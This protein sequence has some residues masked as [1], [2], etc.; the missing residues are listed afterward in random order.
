MMLPS[1]NDAA[2]TIAENFGDYI[3]DEKELDE[4]DYN[5]LIEFKIKKKSPTLSRMDYFLS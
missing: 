5:A 2:V 3:E 1:G 4:D